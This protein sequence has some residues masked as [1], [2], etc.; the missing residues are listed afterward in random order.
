MADRVRAIECGGIGAFRTLALNSGLVDAIN[1]S[2][3]VLKRHL[4][5]HE[6]DH[7]LNIACNTLTGGTCLDDIELRRNDEAFMDGLGVER[8]P[9]PTTAGDF[10]RRFCE[11][12]VFGLTDA[13]NV[14]R[15][16]IWKKRLRRSER[17]EA[18]I[19][20]DG[21]HAPTWGECKEG[22]W[23]TFFVSLLFRFDMVS[24]LSYKMGASPHGVADRRL[25][26]WE[27]SGKF[28]LADLQL[29]GRPITQ[30]TPSLHPLTGLSRL[31]DLFGR[32]AQEFSNPLD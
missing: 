24:P 1:E 20:V 11:E 29:P 32:H 17:R 7:V 31:H 19:D 25:M 10:T 16:K 15:P 27:F 13:V 23:T 3:H 12:D 4:P 18:I 21:T 8:I 22:I 9:D 5:Y 26:E 28:G 30:N 2:T 14:I 6:S